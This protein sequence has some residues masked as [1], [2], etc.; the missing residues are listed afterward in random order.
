[1]VWLTTARFLLIDTMVWLINTR[2]LLIDARFFVD[3][4]PVVVD[5]CKRYV[6]V[7]QFDHVIY[8]V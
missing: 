3:K 7:D 8:Y 4:G 1:M 6:F 5:Q 2:F